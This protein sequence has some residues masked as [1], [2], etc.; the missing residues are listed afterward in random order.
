[1][2][3]LDFDTGFYKRF[4]RLRLMIGKSRDYF[5]R[6][7]GF[8]AS[9]LRG[10]ESSNSGQRSF[11]AENLDYYIEIYEKYLGVVVTREWLL[12]GT[13]N[14]P[15]LKERILISSDTTVDLLLNELPFF[16]LIDRNMLLRRV[17]PFY[18]NILSNKP[19][20]DIEGKHIEDILG[21]KAFEDYCPVFKEALEGRVSRYPFYPI[22]AD[23]ENQK[24]LINCKP[25]LDADKEIIG[26]FNFIEKGL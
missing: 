17:N 20:T 26:I 22:K 15:L 12:Y 6:N 11:K 9:T 21:R 10:W 14:P 1:M 23:K 3:K 25:A 24:I 8:S 18:S 4:Q 19:L 16:F 5:E 13:G 7:F 2:Y